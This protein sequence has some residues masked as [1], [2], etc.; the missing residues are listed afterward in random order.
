MLSLSFIQ[1]IEFTVP[2]KVN[3]PWSW[4]T[5]AD[6]VYPAEGLWFLPANY[7]TIIKREKK[8]VIY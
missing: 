3:L 1:F 6:F 4:V 2:K 7:L 8:Q 5:L